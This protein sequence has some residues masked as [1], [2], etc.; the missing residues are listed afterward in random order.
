MLSTFSEAGADG[1][2]FQALAHEVNIKEDNYERLVTGVGLHGRLQKQDQLSLTWTWHRSRWRS[3]PWARESA[4]SSLKG[5]ALPELAGNNGPISQGLASRVG[6]EETS[7]APRDPDINTRAA[8]P[9][10]LSWVEASGREQSL[11]LFVLKTQEARAVVRV[12]APLNAPFKQPLLRNFHSLPG[13][14]RS[15]LNGHRGGL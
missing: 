10:S 13:P 1:N 15:I 9:G 2:L 8:G 12:S 5:A 6:P 3:L 11:H 7:L 4:S 14:R